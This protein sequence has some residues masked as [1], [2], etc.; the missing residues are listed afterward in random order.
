M[1][2]ILLCIASE[3]GEIDIYGSRAHLLYR[4]EFDSRPMRL[5]T[6]K[7][8]FVA[9][10]WDGHVS[11]MSSRQLEWQSE[12]QGAVSALSRLGNDF[13]AGTWDGQVTRLSGAN[14]KLI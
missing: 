9:G 2:P 10:S 6:H 13:L 8:G 11:Y 4:E 1:N 12:L 7:Q 3:A 14:G 5:I